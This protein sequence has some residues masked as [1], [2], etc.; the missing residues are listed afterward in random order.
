MVVILRCVTP[1]T[2]EQLFSGK[3]RSFRVLTSHPFHKAFDSFL[4]VL[5]RKVLYLGQ[6]FNPTALRIAALSF[7]E[8]HCYSLPAITMAQSRFEKPPLI[9]ACYAPLPGTCTSMFTHRAP[10][11]LSVY[12]ASGTCCARTCRSVTCMR[13]P[14]VSWRPATG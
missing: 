5:T 6:T 13:G 8:R 1:A 12:S 2:I 3:G 11:K 4:G 10:L 9:T 7:L 14:N